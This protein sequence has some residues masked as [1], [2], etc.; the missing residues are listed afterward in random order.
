[1]D[2]VKIG[3]LGIVAVLLSI[4]VKQSRPEFGF[5]IILGT[6]LCIL[7]MVLSYFYNISSVF[8][9]F[10]AYL[11]EY[12]S[13]LELLLKVLGITYICEFCA[14]LCRDAGYGS[15]AGQIELSGKLSVLMFGL[16]ILLTLL[17]TLKSYGG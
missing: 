6:S 12:K 10:Y 9:S 13:Y 3:F 14:S 8:G 17:E 16:P 7:T 2:I 11:G 15:I 5:Y 4:Q 1:M